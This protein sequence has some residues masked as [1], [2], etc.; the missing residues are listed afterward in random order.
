[1]AQENNWT[2]ICCVEGGVFGLRAS[3]NSNAEGFAFLSRGTL[4]LQAEYNLR[5]AR[6]VL[7]ETE[8]SWQPVLVIPLAKILNWEKKIVHS[9]DRQVVKGKIILWT[10]ALDDMRGPEKIT[11]KMDTTGFEQFFDSLR[12]L[13]G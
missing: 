2:N 1:M 13:E 11:L 10:S 8:E 3:T 12:S 6:V 5:Q 9:K 7:A 4:L